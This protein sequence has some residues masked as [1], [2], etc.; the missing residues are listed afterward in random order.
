M[1]G[2]G[3]EKIEI[4]EKPDGISFDEIHKLLWKANE[5]NRADGFH[6]QTAE[7]SGDA[8]REKLHP[9]GKCFVALA[10]GKLAGTLSI[11]IVSRKRWYYHGMIP[12]YILAAVLPEYQGRHINTMLS[13]KAFEYARENGYT[14]IVLDTAEENRHAIQVY[15]HQGFCLADYVVRE[16]ADHNSVVMVKWL[17]DP[18][19]SKSY[20]K[21]R[22]R[23]ARTM[24]KWKAKK[25]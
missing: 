7:L 2:Q 12:N 6:L 4:M 21:L 3:E 13:E 10:D 20:M 5:G 1:S 24:K 22:F 8:I 19:F 18:P 11:K 23:M 9:D 16:N 14:A 25:K 17:G 15:E